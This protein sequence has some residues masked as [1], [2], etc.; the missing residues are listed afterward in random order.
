MI[1]RFDAEQPQVKIKE[2]GNG[3]TAVF[4]CTD[5]NWYEETTDSGTYRF[6]ECNYHEIIG[7]TEAIPLEDIKKNP[8]AYMYYEIP[9]AKPMS[10][11]EM[12]EEL[13]RSMAELIEKVYNK[14]D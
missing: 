14:E 4:L 5:G 8:S 3:K 11:S 2:L 1:A 12:I 7:K 9:F 10:E 6:W 13:K